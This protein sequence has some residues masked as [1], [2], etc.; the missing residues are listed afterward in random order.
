MFEGLLD[1]LNAEQRPLLWSDQLDLPLSLGSAYSTPTLTSILTTLN[2]AFVGLFFD[3]DESSKVSWSTVL[4]FWLPLWPVNSSLGFYWAITFYT[5]Y[6][7]QPALFFL[8]LRRRY[9][10]GCSSE[11]CYLNPLKLKKSWSSSKEYRL[12]RF[13]QNIGKLWKATH[14]TN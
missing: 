8:R 1:K 6:S 3:A 7:C 10:K 5:C 14:S 2:S 11:H 13:F 9:A 4:F 12:S